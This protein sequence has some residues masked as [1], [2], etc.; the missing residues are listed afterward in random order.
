MFVH[1][2]DSTIMFMLVMVLNICSALTSSSSKLD[3]LSPSKPNPLQKYLAF[4]ILGCETS[5]YGRDME[6]IPRR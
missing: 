3:L 1:N 4:V 6:F 2:L 5:N